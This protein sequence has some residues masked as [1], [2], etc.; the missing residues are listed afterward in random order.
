MSKNETRQP[1]D[2]KWFNRTWKIQSASSSLAPGNLG[3]VTIADRS[4]DHEITYSGRGGFSQVLEYD[5]LTRCLVT[6]DS[7]DHE[8]RSIS[9]WK[10]TETAH[11]I[12]AMF[13]RE[14]EA[15]GIEAPFERGEHGTWGADDG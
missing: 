3:T 14:G 10:R 13:R 15:D 8:Q 6:K 5:E 4:G 7:S 12:Y 9:F 11:C 2:P 1:F